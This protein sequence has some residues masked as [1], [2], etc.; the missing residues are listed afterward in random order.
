VA[1]VLVVAA[2]FALWP[3]GDQSSGTTFALPTESPATIAAARLRADLPA[4]PTASAPVTSP[5]RGTQVTCLATGRPA[6]LGA[7]VAGA[8]TLLN[9]W[10]TWCVPCRHELPALGAYAA[11]PG[12]IRVVGVQVRSEQADGLNLL[13]DLKVRLPMLF[14]G[15]NPPGGTLLNPATLPASYLIGADGT[16]TRITAPVSVFTS[17]DQVKAAVADY[18]PAAAR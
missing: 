9:V 15:S 11:A 4:C 18:L 5:L 7:A 16:V 14:A 13:A 6:D 8:P 17:P 1:L 12:A 10:A 3:R 2:A